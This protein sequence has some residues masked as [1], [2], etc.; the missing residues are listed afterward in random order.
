MSGEA[1]R[2]LS[3]VRHQMQGP[4]L[5]CEGSS[6]LCGGPLLWTGPGMDTVLAVLSVCTAHSTLMALSTFVD[7][8]AELGAIATWSR[9]GLPGPKICV[10]SAH[11]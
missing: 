2:T 5:T 6:A 8:L 9:S 11:M 1:P 10:G 4:A 3:A 7:T